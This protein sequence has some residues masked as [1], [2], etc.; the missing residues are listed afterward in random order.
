LQLG[1]SFT[2][3]PHPPTHR[4]RHTVAPTETQGNGRV[5]EGGALA[6]RGHWAFGP[7]PPQPFLAAHRLQ[8]AE[9][10]PH[11]H[12]YRCVVDGSGT[13]PGW[14]GDCDSASL[15][16]LVGQPTALSP[17][18]THEHRDA[19]VQNLSTL[20][21]CAPVFPVLEVNRAS[22]CIWSRPREDMAMRP[23][24]T[25]TQLPHLGKGAVTIFPQT[26]P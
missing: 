24:V 11:W 10:S 25:R 7:C 4:T 9:A 20:P 18:S 19:E 3:T 13:S 16:L 14:G 23:N 22:L 1:A 15:C 8:M 5:L 12:T 17:E 26:V 6:S 2:F 21:A